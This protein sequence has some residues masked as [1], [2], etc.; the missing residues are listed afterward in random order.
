MAIEGNRC[1][2]TEQGDLGL[3]ATPVD[4]NAGKEE[5]KNE[6]IKSGYCH[7]DKVDKTETKEK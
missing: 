6:K 4:E 1:A 2:I 3:G 7:C 5:S